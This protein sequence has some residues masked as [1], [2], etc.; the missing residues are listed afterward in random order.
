MGHCIDIS[1]YIV[2]TWLKFSSVLLDLIVTRSLPYP[3]PF[4]WTCLLVFPRKNC[5]VQHQNTGYS[6]FKYGGAVAIATMGMDGAEEAI[7]FPCE[8]LVLVDNC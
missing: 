1:Y 2:Q 8:C 6:Y 3:L 4:S 5:V 7:W